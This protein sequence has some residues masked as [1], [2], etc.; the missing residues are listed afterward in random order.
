ME[1]FGFLTLGTTLL[2][3]PY[4]VFIC[5]VILV[6]VWANIKMPPNSMCLML[7]IFLTPNIA[8]AFGLCF[9]PQNARVGRL[10]CYY[11]TGSYNASFVMLLSLTTANIAGH[12][13][14]VTASGILFIGYC[15]GNIAGPF[16]YKTSQKPIYQLGIWS[17]IVSHILEAICVILLWIHL[18]GENKKRDAN[19]YLNGNMVNSQNCEMALEDSTDKENLDFRYVF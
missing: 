5:V 18:R 2:Q 15:T 6:C 1:G 16:F 14:K 3:I 12:T 7:L 9:V 10:I 17:M 8:A 19:Q 4:G 13:K 11:L